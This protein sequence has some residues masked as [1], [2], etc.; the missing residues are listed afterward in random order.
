MN[1]SP[2]FVFKPAGF[3]KWPADK[4]HLQQILRPVKKVLSYFCHLQPKLRP[5]NLIIALK[6]LSD[7][8]VAKLVDSV[9]PLPSGRELSKAKKCGVL[10]PDC[11]KQ[12]P[13]EKEI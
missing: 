13:K 6:R 8:S 9:R 10:M 7:S 3:N 2:F 4:Y 1:Y 5:Q 12:S 11:K